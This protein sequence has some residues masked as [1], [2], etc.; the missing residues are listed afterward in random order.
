M[1]STPL[2][3]DYTNNAYQNI[4][5]HLISPPLPK[6]ALQATGLE[7]PL[8]PMIAIADDHALYLLEFTD[9]KKLDHQIKHLQQ[10]TKSTITLGSAKPLDSIKT[11]LTKYF[12]GALDSFKT[13]IHLLGTPFQNSV[14]E[15]LRTIPYGATQSYLDL[16]KAL[17]NPAAFRAVALANS[18][19][20]LAII[21]PCHR[22]INTNGKLGGY[23]GG[24]DRKTWLIQHEKNNFS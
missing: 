19:N 17:K 22:V 24:L 20:P 5:S 7:T 4:L 15:A 9:R 11:E 6:L 13:P 23:A 18:K 3:H 8:G 1:I 14:W 2:S 10:K 21:V 12:N 16:A